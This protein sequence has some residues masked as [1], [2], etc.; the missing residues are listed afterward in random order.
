MISNR[1]CLILHIK[2]VVNLV[3]NVVLDDGV[4]GEL[5]ELFHLVLDGLALLDHVAHHLLQPEGALVGAGA[6]HKVAKTLQ[7]LKLIAHN[8]VVLL[9]L[10]HVDIVDALLH[11]NDDVEEVAGGGDEGTVQLEDVAPLAHAVNDDGQVG[12]EVM[13]VSAKKDLGELD[14]LVVLLLHVNVVI[15]LKRVLEVRDDGE[16]RLGAPV[17]HGHEVL[18]GLVVLLAPLDASTDDSVLGEEIAQRQ[19]ATSRPRIPEDK[20]PIGMDSG[21]DAQ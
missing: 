21:A 10:L 8:T 20:D 14:N 5:A 6:W 2:E 4:A 16:N 13:H 18:V 17:V 15:K 3:D 9:D 7:A 19:A 11:L 12:L 1:C